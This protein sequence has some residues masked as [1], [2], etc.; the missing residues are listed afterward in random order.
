VNSSASSAWSAKRLDAVRQQV[1]N[2]S[3]GT[4]ARKPVAAGKK[5]VVAVIQ[6]DEV[7]TPCV[8]LA[9]LGALVGVW[10]MCVF[11]G[12]QLAAPFPSPKKPGVARV[13]RRLN[14][15]ASSALDVQR[16]GVLDCDVSPEKKA[17]VD[18]GAPSPAHPET[19]FV[20]ADD[21]LAADNSIS[22]LNSD[23]LVRSRGLRRAWL[24]CVCTFF[25]YHYEGR[26]L[27]RVL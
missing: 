18:G 1:A 13:K 21:S 23:D 5:P 22:S 14:K 24:V 11:G 15:S 20:F 17:M 4:V 16:L 19:S 27:R 26:C 25:F 2:T 3:S 10:C 6:S 7:G 9:F 8:T 12:V